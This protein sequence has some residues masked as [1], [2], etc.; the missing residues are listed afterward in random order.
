MTDD[1]LVEI[2][3]DIITGIDR[4]LSYFGKNVCYI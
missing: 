2:I 3:I 4:E 1:A